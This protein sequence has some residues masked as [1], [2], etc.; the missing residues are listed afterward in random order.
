MVAS[1]AAMIIER[2][3]RTLGLFLLNVGRRVPGY[4]EVP[5]RYLALQYDVTVVTTGVIIRPQP[6]RS[7]IDMRS[8]GLYRGEVS[9]GVSLPRRRTLVRPHIA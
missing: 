2:E 3:V 8:G 6:D 4:R 1:L 9:A 7:G 5:R